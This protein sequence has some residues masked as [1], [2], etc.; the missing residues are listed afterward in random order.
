MNYFQPATRAP[1][2]ARIAIA[3]PSG[4]GKTPIAL[5][6]AKRF[7]P[8]IAL[9]DTN[10]GQATVYADRYS[11]SLAYLE[12][13]HPRSF[14]L[15]LKEVQQ[16]NYDVVI[17]DTLTPLWTGRFGILDY[18]D[19]AARTQFQGNRNEAWGSARKLYQ[20]F[21]DTLLNL[22]QHVICTLRSKT[23]HLVM[24]VGGRTEIR[25]VG[26]D[27]IAPEQF[28]Y[29]VDC[30]GELA[31]DHTLT[32]TKSYCTPLMDQSFTF[33]LTEEYTLNVDAFALPLKD[34]LRSGTGT[35]PRPVVFGPLDASGSDN[36]ITGIPM[37]SATP[38]DPASSTPT[39]PSDSPPPTPD[40]DA[41]SSPTVAA[42][43]EPALPA[44]PEPPADRKAVIQDLSKFSVAIGIT[45][46]K[47]L[48]QFIQNAVGHPVVLRTISDED[49]RKAWKT[50]FAKAAEHQ[51]AE[52]QTLGDAFD[53]VVQC[54]QSAK[55]TSLE[56]LAQRAET[57]LGHP[58]SDLRALSLDDLHQ[59]EQAL[60]PTPVS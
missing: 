43:A 39:T 57:V 6:L 53:R 28:E 22:P 13:F 17:L 16:Q 27:P 24:Q 7:G 10:R 26:L 12:N 45:D 37:D 18:V 54:A 58:V 31:A 35:A 46:P 38:T 25:R 50:L 56:A 11:F 44:P 42:P 49:A 15:L 30:V 40:A 33:P 21:L 1:R 34:W 19:H 55:I 8:K 5:E 41:A 29:E 32:V 48:K 4:A 9:I 59:L 36:T 2:P 47:D 3:G 51:A 52:S 60:T 14:T 20:E 23:E